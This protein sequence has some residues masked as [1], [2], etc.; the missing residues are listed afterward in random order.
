[1][2]AR[3]PLQPNFYV[4]ENRPQAFEAKLEHVW[5]NTLHHPEGLDGRIPDLIIF[6]RCVGAV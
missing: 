6:E 4:G 1:L 5:H 2:R 3:S